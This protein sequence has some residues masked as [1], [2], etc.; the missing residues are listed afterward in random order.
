[1]VV[2]EVSMI[3]LTMIGMIDNHCKIAK[4]LDIS[5]LDLFRGHP[6]IF[7]ADLFL[8]F[9]YSGYSV[10]EGTK[11]GA[12]LGRGRSIWHQFKQVIILDKQMRQLEDAPFRDLLSRARI[13]TLTKVD[14]SVLNIKTITSL[15][16][17]Q[18][19]DA[20]LSSS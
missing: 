17:P 15:V 1:M 4:S 7:I 3:D 8:V 16:S 14:R 6:I 12:M 13:G 2:D 9:T 20:P 11:K 5:S 10:I 19:E 18:L